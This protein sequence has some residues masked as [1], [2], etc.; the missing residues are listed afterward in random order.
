VIENCDDKMMSALILISV[1]EFA[2]YTGLPVM[3]SN[4][5][6]PVI[7]IFVTAAPSFIYVRLHLGRPF[8]CFALL[9]NPGRTSSFGTWTFH[10]IVFKR[11]D[12]AQS[13]SEVGRVIKRA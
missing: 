9:S 5:G 1:D 4:D 6:W 12:F 11:L 13:D 2:L 10:V 3:I 7:A 8:G